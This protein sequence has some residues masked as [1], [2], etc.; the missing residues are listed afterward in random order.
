MDDNELEEILEED[1]RKPGL[2]RFIRNRFITG[3]IIALPLVATVWLITAFV[4]FIDRMVLRLFPEEWN[5][6]LYVLESTG[7]NIPGTGLLVAFIGLVLLGFLASN[8]IGNKLLQL[9]GNLLG[10]VPF[11]SNIYN[12]VKQIVNTVAKSEE[13]NFNEVCLVEYP[14]PGLWAIGFVTANLKGAPVRYLKDD[15]VSIFVPTTPNPTSGFLLF[16]K[17]ADIKILD[18]TPEEGAKMIISGGIVSNEELEE[19]K[20]AID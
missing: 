3:V 20:D 16:S 2:L 18:M 5:P 14:R 6:N 15:Y 7:Y 19:V 8:F 17:R 12:G 4:G 13:R 10:R 9:G 11:V 1:K